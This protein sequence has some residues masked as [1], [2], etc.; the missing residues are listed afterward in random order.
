MI[1]LAFRLVLCFP[2]EANYYLQ[3]YLYISV[4]FR[5]YP[6]L[7]TFTEIPKIDISLSVAPL[8]FSILTM[9]FALF[10]E[11]LKCFDLWEN[12]IVLAAYKSLLI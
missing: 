5:K 2:R 4:L 12:L 9:I 6:E 8:L 3:K 11:S 1:L 10:T 7:H